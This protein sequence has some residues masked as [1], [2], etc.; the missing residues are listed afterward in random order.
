MVRPT[1]EVFGAVTVE[2][3]PPPVPVW[4]WAKAALG[5]ARATIAS[6]RGFR[7]GPDRAAIVI[8]SK[9]LF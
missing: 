7:A 8:G 6:Q 1:E 4:A 5:R 2:V 3:G 9:S